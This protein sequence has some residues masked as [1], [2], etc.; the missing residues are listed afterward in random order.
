MNPLGEAL[1]SVFAP[2]S[3]KN[4]EIVPLMGSKNSEN[5]PIFPIF[6]GK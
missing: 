6:L 3:P 2:I 1:K 4:S 5:E